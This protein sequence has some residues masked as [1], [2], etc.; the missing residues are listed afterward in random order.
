MLLGGATCIILNKKL[1]KAIATK[2]IKQAVLDLGAWFLQLT[3][4]LSPT[5]KRKYKT[6][7]SLQKWT[8]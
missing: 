7:S 2:G 1:A 3:P 5:S 8:N 6:G 4:P